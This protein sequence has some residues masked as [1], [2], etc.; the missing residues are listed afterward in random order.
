MCKDSYKALFKYKAFNIIPLDK[1]AT[2][3]YSKKEGTTIIN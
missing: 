1:V 2:L 3:S